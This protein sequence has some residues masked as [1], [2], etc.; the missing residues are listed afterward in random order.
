MR[1]RR[2]SSS[3]LFC[4]EFDFSPSHWTCLINGVSSNCC[5]V[6]FH[7]TLFQSLLLMQLSGPST[8]H[9]SL[10][11]PAVV[12]YA[13]ASNFYTP[14]IEVIWWMTRLHSKI[15]FPLVFI[16]FFTFYFHLITGILFTRFLLCFVQ[17][18]LMCERVLLF[19]FPAFYFWFLPWMYSCVASLVDTQ[20][21]R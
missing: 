7:D 8:P 19:S 16:L 11:K 13:C 20:G 9:Y 21:L 15:L 18:F 14:L 6:W 5:L 4:C 2:K 17:S 3:R 10:S 12:V 1:I